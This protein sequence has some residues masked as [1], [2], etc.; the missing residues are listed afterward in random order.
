MSVLYQYLWEVLYSINIELCILSIL[1]CYNCTQVN[2]KSCCVVPEE[3]SGFAKSNKVTLLTHSDPGELL[4]GDSLRNMLYP[5]LAREAGHYA[6]DWVAR[7]KYT[8]TFIYL[9]HLSFCRYQVQLKDR[10]VLLQK[11]YLSKLSNACIN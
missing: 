9:F 3:L 5:K 10:G 2:L 8:I 7:Y 11:R 6:A 1:I 4:P